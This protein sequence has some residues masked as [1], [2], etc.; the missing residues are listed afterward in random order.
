MVTEQ[1][2][3]N[4]PT[5]AQSRAAEAAE[6]L[7]TEGQPV[8]AR[9]VRVR[10]E[11]ATNVAAEAA[12]KWNESTA[13]AVPE[14]PIPDNVM[15]RYAA[16]WRESQ[17]EA[18]AKFAA[19]RDAFMA[20]LQA[21]NDEIRELTGDLTEAEAKIEELSAAVA[22]AKAALA[23]AERAAAV[24]A[25]EQAALLS[26]ERTRADRADVLLEAVSAERDRLLETVRSM[27]RD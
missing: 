24:R 22:D 10:A 8:T 21:S 9:T 27:T 13:S 12:R 6:A 1:N 17:A 14:T 4:T 23:D 16:A 5:P 2:A 3:S 19:E 11:V 26:T 25:D 18:S 20:K 15:A 7:A